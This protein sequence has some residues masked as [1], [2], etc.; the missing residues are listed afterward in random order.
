VTEDAQPSCIHP[1]VLTINLARMSEHNEGYPGQPGEAPTEAPEVVEVELVEPGGKPV[2][3][4][5]KKAAPRKPEH[6]A[7]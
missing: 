1:R 6:K 4:T 5:L 7:K 3:A 2:P